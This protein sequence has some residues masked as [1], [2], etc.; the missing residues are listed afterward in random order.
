MLFD[1]A[2]D[3]Y[4]NNFTDSGKKYDNLVVNCL[5]CQDR[6]DQTIQFILLGPH[7]KA[8]RK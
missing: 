4:C 1:N 8:Y 2:D 6:P 5:D 3:F 7:D